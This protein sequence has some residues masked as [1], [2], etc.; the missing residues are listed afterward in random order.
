MTEGLAVR[1]S[2]GRYCLALAALVAVGGLTPIGCSF[3][4]RPQPVQVR[5]PDEAVPDLELPV[6][7]EAVGS[8]GQQA[9][10]IAA[11]TIKLSSFRGKKVVC[12]FLSS[13]T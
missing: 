6:L 8:D 10:P 5:R 13:Y 2:R 7:T 4:S 12:L 1:R 3:K 9:S 11:E